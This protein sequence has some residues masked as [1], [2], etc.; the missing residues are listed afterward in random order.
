MGSRKR[1]KPQPPEARRLRVPA[2]AKYLSIPEDTLN[3][4]RSRGGG[5]M[6]IKVGRIVLYDTAD[7]DAWLEDNKYAS[8][9]EK[10]G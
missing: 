7:L 3:Q 2:A 4:L 6:F 8:T 5:P 1:T 10:C 9:A